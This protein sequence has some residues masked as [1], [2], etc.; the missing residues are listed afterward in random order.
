MRACRGTEGYERAGGRPGRLAL[1]AAVWSFVTRRAGLNHGACLTAG[2][3]VDGTG[4]NSGVA[5]ALFSERPPFSSKG[6]FRQDAQR[7]AAFC[8]NAP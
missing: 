1:A 2:A 3:V 4:E 6:A 7:R 8:L 5:L